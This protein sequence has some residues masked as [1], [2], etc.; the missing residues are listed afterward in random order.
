MEMRE[1]Q[2]KELG[3]LDNGLVEIGMNKALERAVRDCMDRPGVDKDRKVT[4][5]ACLRP[6]SDEHGVCE[7]VE[8]VFKVK[9][10]SPVRET[11]AYPFSARTR[12]GKPVLTYAAETPVPD[13]EVVS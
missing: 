11:K 4:L 6:V 1:F 5:E 10:T 12:A 2:F 9:D 8:I 3:T 7:E 13:Y